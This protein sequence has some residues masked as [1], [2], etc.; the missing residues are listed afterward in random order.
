MNP[1]MLEGDSVPEGAPG[2]S[3]VQCAA[4]VDRYGISA[5]GSVG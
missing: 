5:G 3:C 1:A 4:P 2:Q